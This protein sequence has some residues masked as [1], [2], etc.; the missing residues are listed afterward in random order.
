MLEPIHEKR[1]LV[2]YTLTENEL[3][4]ISY[5]NTLST[6]SFSVGSFFLSAAV[7][8]A[9]GHDFSVIFYGAIVFSLL[10]FVNGLIAWNERKGLAEKIKSDHVTTKEIAIDDA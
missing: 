7:S 8:C 9:I 2:L 1:R 10:A 6:A 4:V 3:E 5:N